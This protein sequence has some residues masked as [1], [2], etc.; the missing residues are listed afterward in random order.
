MKLKNSGD[1][2]PELKVVN[3]T[4]SKHRQS[5]AVRVFPM[6]IVSVL[7][8][9]YHRFMKRPEKKMAKHVI[10]SIILICTAAILLIAA[11]NIAGFAEWYSVN[12]YSVITATIGRLTGI[13]PFSVAEAAVCI[14]PFIIITDIVCCRKRLGAMCMHIV[15]IVSVLFFLYAAN[16]GINYH[17][18]TFVDQ[19]TLLDAVFTKEQL[20]DFCEYIIDRLDEC[21]SASA[22]PQ[23]KELSDSARISMKKIS[24][25]YPSLRGYYP[26][27][28]QLTLLS[29]AFSGMG[30]SGIYS[31]FTVEANINGEMPD[32]EKP[33]TS[34]HELSHLRGYMNEGEANY[35]GWLACTG[36]DDPSFN[37]SGWLIA[38]MH[39]GGALRRIDPESYEKLRER[40]P[41]YA[42][43]E[44]EENTMF[45]S[46]H[47]TKAAEVQDRVNDA[48]LKANDQKDGI[49]SYG[50]LT[51]L[52]LVNYYNIGV[53]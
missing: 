28:K 9:L 50:M 41:S 45:W 10:L 47:E 39:A 38:W 32:M 12:I 13:F 1:F 33:F 51:T 27:P 17:R 44:I 11:R 37:R 8:M 7:C 2:S 48:Y 26:A 20:E 22:Y 19:D 25:M 4:E 18:N 49:Q 53:R 52:M 40:L 6:R 31:P 42:V 36:S 34:C 35:I 24:E 16:C 5:I 43:S 15:L 21:E 46:S 3:V 23:G 14:L 29:R 30:V